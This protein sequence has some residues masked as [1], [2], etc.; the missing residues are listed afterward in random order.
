MVKCLNAVLA[1]EKIKPAGL[2]LK[3]KEVDNYRIS[4]P[5]LRG[6]DTA[7][8]EYAQECKAAA[9]V[10]EAVAEEE[11]PAVEESPEE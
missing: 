6:Y 8:F 2:K 10:E 3:K 7:C 9:L 5:L 1:E 4:P 11:A